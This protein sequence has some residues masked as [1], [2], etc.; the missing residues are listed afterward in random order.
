M[1][2]EQASQEKGK[3][4]Q[5]RNRSISRNQEFFWLKPQRNTVASSHNILTSW[6]W[7]LR[8]QENVKFIF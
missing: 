8:R 1:T 2:N 7:V 4:S 5:N 6:Q 3:W